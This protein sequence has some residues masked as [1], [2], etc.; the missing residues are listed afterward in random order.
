MS[1]VLSLAI[2]AAVLAAAPQ[3]RSSCRAARDGKG[4]NSGM[5]CALVTPKKKAVC[6]RTH[7]QNASAFP[8]AY[9]TAFKRS[10]LVLGQHGAAAQPL[11][12]AGCSSG[13]EGEGAKL[14]WST[15]IKCTDKINRDFPVINTV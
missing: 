9:K 10:G 3:E 2:G 1:V 8:P 13:L 12:A 4:G 7:P 14:A 6:S 11:P 5:K 15:S